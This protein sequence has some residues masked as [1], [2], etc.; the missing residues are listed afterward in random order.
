MTRDE[1]TPWDRRIDAGLDTTDAGAYLDLDAR[2]FRRVRLSGGP[3][4]DLLAVTVDDHLASSTP[5]SATDGVLRG[6]SRYAAGAVVSPRATIEYEALPWLSPV[7]SYGEGFR[8]LDGQSVKEGSHSPYSK[9]RSAEAG[10]HMRLLEDRYAATA[11]CFE[12]WVANEL[13][14]AAEAGGLET[15]RASTRRGFVGSIVAKPSDWLLASSALSFT[16]AVFDTRVPGVA[17]FVPNVPPVLWRTD[18]TA[19]GKLGRIRSTPLTGRVG[20]GYT[21]LSGRHLTD[22]LTGPAN[23]AL[24]ASLALRLGFVE[25]GADAYNLLGLRYA[26]D[27]AVYAS[28]WSTRPGQQ[29]ASV[30]THW[31]AAPPRT[32]LGTVSLYF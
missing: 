31:T 18:V 12:T 26:D 16:N 29:L 32:V 24:N 17:H 2:I 19:R 1:W 27:A 14:F 15:E 6:V 21:L 23:H 11:A 10:L 20:V 9:V 30:A 4:V 25:I 7:L 22:T 28:N 8:S 5:T 3:R 13:V